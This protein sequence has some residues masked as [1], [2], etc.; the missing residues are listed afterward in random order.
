MPN[1]FHNNFGKFRKW[2]P[3]KIDGILVWHI[4]KGPRV[5]KCSK[6]FKYYVSRLKIKIMAYVILEHF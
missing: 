2:N 5:F 6:V 3:P 4:R 1:S